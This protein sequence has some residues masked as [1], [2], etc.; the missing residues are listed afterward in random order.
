MRERFAAAGP[1]SAVETNVGGHDHSTASSEEP[2][3]ARWRDAIDA[4]ADR[5]RGSTSSISGGGAIAAFEDLVSGACESR[6][7][8][9]VSS[10]TTALAA[11]LYAVGV[12]RGTEVIC[13]ALDWTSAV[14]AVRLVGA[15][16][17]LVD[18]DPGSL[19][20]CPSSAAAAVTPRTSAVIATHLFGV[21][22]DVPTIAS[23]TGV[24]VVEDC[25]QAWGASWAGTPVG[26]LGDAAAF[27]FGPGKHLDAGEGGAAVFGTRRAWAAAV[28][29][30]QHPV[31]QRLA[32]HTTARLRLPG[33]IH[34][35]AAVLG[36]HAAPEATRRVAEARTLVTD[37]R[38]SRPD[39]SLPG[40]DSDRSPSW[41]RLAVPS[42]ALPRPGSLGVAPIPA[43]LARHVPHSLAASQTLTAVRPN[44]LDSLIDTDRE[45]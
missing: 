25:A 19:T 36:L 35:M 23:A 11:C 15:R 33:R 13:S 27:S 30:T 10:G 24:P 37:L 39:L 42:S 20:L 22:A 3:L 29:M 5:A 44:E 2:L 14:D 31:R 43:R 28:A 1:A 4:W 32:G 45:T 26:A 41:W 38:R 40:L 34:P 18:V 21:P 9:A 16:P 8:V 6:P 7:V 17:R 12:R